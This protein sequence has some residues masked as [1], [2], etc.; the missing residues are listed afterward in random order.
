MDFSWCENELHIGLK[1]LWVSL[2]KLVGIWLLN[3]NDAVRVEKSMLDDGEMDFAKSVVLFFF[4]DGASSFC[5]EAVDDDNEEDGDKQ[6]WVF[7]YLARRFLNH[8]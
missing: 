4:G 5:G 2:Y 8:T 1:V 7:L 6:R 3:G